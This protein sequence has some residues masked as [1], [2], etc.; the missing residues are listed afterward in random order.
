MEVR[1]G[2]GGVRW[3]WGEVE[4]ELGGGTGEG[5]HEGGEGAVEHL[6]EGVSAGEPLGAT[7]HR[8]LQD[9]GDPRAV[10]GGGPQHDTGEENKCTQTVRNKRTPDL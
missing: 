7:Q 1:W 8:V 6:E 2:G 4:M 3:R 5:V 10:P 9:V